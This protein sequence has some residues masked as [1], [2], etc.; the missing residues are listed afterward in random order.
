MGPVKPIKASCFEIESRK[1]EPAFAQIVAQNCILP[2]RRLAVCSEEDKFTPVPFT[3]CE[4]TAMI[5]PVHGRIAAHQYFKGLRSGFVH[6]WAPTFSESPYFHHQGLIDGAKL[7]SDPT[8]LPIIL[9]NLRERSLHRAR[10]LSSRR[11][12]RQDTD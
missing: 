2:Y 12:T 10:E 1:C 7:H 3:R 5:E 4:V 11:A 9:Q 6:G 8:R